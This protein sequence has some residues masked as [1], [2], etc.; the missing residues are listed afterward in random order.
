MQIGVARLHRGRQHD[1]SAVPNR[2]GWTVNT[3]KLWG[4][5]AALLALWIVV[6][7]FTISEVA[8]VAPL[9]ISTR[10]QAPHASVQLADRA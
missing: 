1:G 7:A 9:L 6:A 3:L 8:T 5:P 10:V 2:K 4:S